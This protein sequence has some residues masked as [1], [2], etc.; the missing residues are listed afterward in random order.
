[1][2]VTTHVN[3][4][5]SVELAWERYADPALWSTWAPQIRSV[6][7][8]GGGTVDRISAGMR[9][10]VHALFGVS[11]RF[12]VTEVDEADHRWA[13]TVHLPAIT[14]RLEHTLEPAGRAR[15]SRTGL[16]VDGPAPVVLAYVP[17]ARLALH[18]LVAAEPV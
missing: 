16:V 3:G 7:V 5:A 12:E 1:M 8:D 10:T 15:G 18:R 13:W 4:P 11:V 14:L 2:R 6:E 17:V 9:G